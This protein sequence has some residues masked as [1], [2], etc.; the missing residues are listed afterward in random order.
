MVAVALGL[1]A[2]GGDDGSADDGAGASERAVAG[3]FVLPDGD[4]ERGAELAKDSGCQSCHQDEDGLGPTWNGLYGSTRTL[5]DG[6]TVTADDDY[7]VLAIREP[8]EQKVDGFSVA[9][10]RYDD[11]SDQEVADLVA[12]IRSLGSS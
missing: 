1:T 6:S 2:C 12:Y 10:P 7:L 5:D 4:A 8:G 9:M 11:L 3:S